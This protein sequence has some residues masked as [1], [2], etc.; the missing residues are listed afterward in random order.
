MLPFPPRSGRHAWRVFVVVIVILTRAG[1]RAQSDA[2]KGQI[3]G[4]VLDPQKRA[5]AGATIRIANPGTGAVRAAA[6]NSE[7][8][9]RAVLL[10]PGTYDVTVEFGGFA[11]S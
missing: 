2:N 10:D 6:S 1:L 3:L 5:V 11:P 4:T 8:E 7:G 9:F